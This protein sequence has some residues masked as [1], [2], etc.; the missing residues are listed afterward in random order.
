MAMLHQAGGSL[1]QTEFAVN[2]DAPL[3]RVAEMLRSLEESGRVTRRW[4]AGEY[5][6]TV[7]R[8]A[9]NTTGDD[10]VV[11]RRLPRLRPG[12]RRLVVVAPLGE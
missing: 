2:L 1:R 11:V 5:T 8:S 4:D 7:E 12:Y 10:R 9:A 3:T 6:H